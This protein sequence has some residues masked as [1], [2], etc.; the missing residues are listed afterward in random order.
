MKND[1]WNHRIARNAWWLS[2]VAVVLTFD[3]LM[4]ASYFWPQIFNHGGDTVATSLIEGNLVVV[5]MMFLSSNVLFLAIRGT[6]RWRRVQ[7]FVLGFVYS[8]LWGWNFSRIVR[9]IFHPGWFFPV[10]VN[11]LLY[12]GLPFLWS[13]SLIF[14][15]LVWKPQISK[16]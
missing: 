14:A 15:A 6:S 11:D 12:F 16:K 9:H 3:L 7:L 13:L 5:T 4:I 1:D 2:G 8:L 10:R